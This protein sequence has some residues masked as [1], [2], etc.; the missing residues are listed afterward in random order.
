MGVW[1]RQVGFAE[2]KGLDK[3]LTTAFFLSLLLGR[4]EFQPSFN[5][6]N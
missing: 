6:I 2:K 1:H 3:E 4:L 5:L